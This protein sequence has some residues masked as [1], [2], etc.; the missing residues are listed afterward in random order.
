MILKN[1]QLPYLTII[2]AIW[3]NRSVYH[4]AT[5]DYEELGP[6]TGHRA[7]GLGER[8]YLDPKSIGRREALAKSE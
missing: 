7:V 8:P 6:R 2:I 1:L 4:A 3:D 5:H